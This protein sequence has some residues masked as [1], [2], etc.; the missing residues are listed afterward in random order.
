MEQN[1]LA[2][3][4]WKN[5]DNTPYNRL[6]ST[7]ADDYLFNYIKAKT[8]NIVLINL[9]TLKR[10]DLVKKFIFLGFEFWRVYMYNEK[11]K[12]NSIDSDLTLSLPVPLMKLF[13]DKCKLMNYLQSRNFPVLKTVCLKSKAIK[14][15]SIEKIIQNVGPIF[16]KPSGGMHSNMCFKSNNVSSEWNAINKIKEK[17]GAL[18]IQPF[19]P[20]FATKANPEIRTYWIGHNLHM[21]YYTVGNGDIIKYRKKAPNAL[22]KIGQNIITQIEKDFNMKFIYCRLDFGRMRP[23]SRTF[24]LNE[25]ELS[26]GLLSSHWSGYTRDYIEKIG[27]ALIKHTK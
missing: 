11:L 17:Y 7:S 6:Y 18:I 10:R 20:S 14:K 24:F 4:N 5:F 19:V 21:C 22:Y 9:E 2:Y 16:I 27:D 3:V 23:R 25:L 8:N 13:A 15:S 1:Q 26:P 12:L